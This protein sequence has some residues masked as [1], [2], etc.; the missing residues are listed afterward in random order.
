MDDHHLPYSS[1]NTTQT[2]KNEKG[3]YTEEEFVNLKKF[4][5]SI[6]MTVLEETVVYQ[7]DKIK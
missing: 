3:T 2:F 6:L 7:R 1:F 4:E 5:K